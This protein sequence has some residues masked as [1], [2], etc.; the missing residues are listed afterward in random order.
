MD[1]VK[2][3]TVS[4]S[5]SA[6]REFFPECT[7]VTMMNGVR[8]SKQQIDDEDFSFEIQI[9]QLN[10]S[11]SDDRAIGIR[12]LKAF[13]FRVVHCYYRD[14]ASAASAFSN[15]EEMHQFLEWMNIPIIEESLFHNKLL[16][17]SLTGTNDAPGRM[18][19]VHCDELVM[20][21][22]L[23]SNWNS[24][25]HQLANH[26]LV[27]NRVDVVKK[28]L[29]LKFYL[30]SIIKYYQ[31]VEDSDLCFCNY[32]LI[33]ARR[34]MR[35]N[36]LRMSSLAMLCILHGFTDTAKMIELLES[37]DITIHDSALAV[38]LE[39]CHSE[40]SKLLSD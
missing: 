3:N 25:H 9:G 20:R 40:V 13:Q 19:P 18:L 10:S 35:N 16:N 6:L 2:F 36:N 8:F 37:H 11:N 28:M 12:M 31:I 7:L 32:T 14:F 22:F 23:C 21:S 5:L 26:A 1:R 27:N 17:A 33:Q 34:W 30:S 29:S 24:M 4:F 15:A 39:Y 38:Y